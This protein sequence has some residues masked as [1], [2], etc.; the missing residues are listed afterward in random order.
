MGPCLIKILPD[1][2]HAV[3]EQGDLIYNDHLAYNQGEVH[4]GLT[5][6]NRLVALMKNSEVD[7]AV[8]NPG[9]TMTYLTGLSFHMMERPVVL[10]V[11]PPAKAV[12]ILPALEA[13]KAKS[14]SIDLTLFTYPDDPASWDK[15]FR[16]ASEHL[17]LAGKV[18]G[19]E[20][21]WLRFLELGYL[22]SAASG[23]K[24]V[25][26]ERIFSHLRSQKTAAE[27]ALMRKAVQIAE[28]AFLNTLPL[29]QAGM[30]EREIAAELTIQLYRAGSDVALPFEPIVAGGE[31]GANPHAI[32]GERIIEH[33]DLI[34]IDWGAR[35]QGYISDLTRMVAVGHIEPELEKI[36]AVVQQANRAGREAC[37]PGRTAAAVDRAAR[38]VIDRAGYGALFTHRTGHGIGM[39]AHESPYIHGGNS[40]AL[41]PGMTFTIEP[42]IYLPG[43]G[44]VRIEDNVAITSDGRE[45]LSTLSRELFTIR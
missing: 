20:P 28:Q 15:V 22:T 27:V 25:S 35:S 7:A 23:A 36:H 24:F 9:P 17:K 41:A 19:V 43:Q 39:E 26:A 38:A 44:G 40:E 31:N 8:I 42:G 32:P 33:G 10:L 16:G 18:I 37:F 5:E 34:V 45:D 12:L 6:L 3:K 4:M 2:L 14:A 1:G 29:M 13:L 30:N 11:A 21:T